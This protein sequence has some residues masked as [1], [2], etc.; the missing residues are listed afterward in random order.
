MSDRAA[1]RRAAP[2]TRLAGDSPRILLIDQCTA[3]W[4]YKQWLG[5]SVPG[6]DLDPSNCNHHCVVPPVGRLLIRGRRTSLMAHGLGCSGDLFGFQ[7]NWPRL[8]RP[9][10]HPRTGG[11]RSRGRSW[12]HGDRSPG[13]S[14]VVPRY[15]CDRRA[16]CNS[17]WPYHCHS[18]VRSGDGARRLRIRLWLRN[19]GSP[20][21]SVLCYIRANSG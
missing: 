15:V 12:R 16:R 11:S 18:P 17:P 4:R 10:T 21:Q 19:L 14:G 7:G 3:I 20:L 13:I 9:R 2:V 8:S 1:L 5:R 6:R